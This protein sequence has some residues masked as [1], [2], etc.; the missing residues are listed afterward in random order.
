MRKGLTRGLLPLFVTVW[1]PVSVTVSWA[2]GL[3]HV[4]SS[5]LTAPS[6]VILYIHSDLKSVDFVQPLVCALQRVLSAPVST[7]TLDLQLGPELLAT[8]TQFD[9]DKVGDQFIRA[10]ATDGGPRSFKYLL[11]PFDLKASPWRYVFS[12]S[13][14]NETTPYHIGVVLTARLD[15]ADPKQQHRGGA[16]ITA[17]RAYKLILKSIARVAGLRSPDACILSFPRSLEELDRKSSEFCS[18]DRAMLVAAHILQPVEGQGHTDCSVIS[19][20]Q[21]VNDVR[22]ARAAE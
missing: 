15:V 11:V 17:R 20:Q 19:Q 10:T 7:Q 6:E 22:V 3:P 14:G 16:E 4:A 9:V 1:L 18:D 5:G 8:P 13:F 21:G 2:Q 12:T